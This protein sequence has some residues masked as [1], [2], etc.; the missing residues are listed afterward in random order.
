MLHYPNISEFNLLGVDPGLNNIGL[1]IY[2]LSLHPFR[3]VSIHSFTLKAERV[4]DTS[5]LRDDIHTDRLRKRHAM[6]NAFSRVLASVN[7]SIVACESPF[8]DRRKPSSFQVLAEILVSLTDAVAKHNPNTLFTTVEPLTVKKI[9]GVAGKKGKEVV[10]EGMV[11]IPEIMSV[12]KTPIEQMD[13]HAI[14]STAV[15]Y[16]FIVKKSGFIFDPPQGG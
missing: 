16:T 15:G 14:D 12:L 2:T 13:E 7:P 9:L 3:I 10:K 8:F 4:I 11:K 5:G 6:I 1:A